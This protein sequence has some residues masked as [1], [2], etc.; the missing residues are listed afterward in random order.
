MGTD[1]SPFKLDY[2]TFKACHIS[3]SRTTVFRQRLD[4]KCMPRIM[5]SNGIKAFEI[6]TRTAY[7]QAAKEWHRQGR[8]AKDG[9]PKMGHI[10]KT[11]I[12]RTAQPGWRRQDGAWRKDFSRQHVAAA[13]MSKAAAVYF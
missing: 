1:G 11:A 2:S 3:D 9:H 8:S 5:G 13:A 10:A 12:A 6:G 7:V 4:A